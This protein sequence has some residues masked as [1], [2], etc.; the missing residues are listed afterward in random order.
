MIS[1]SRRWLLKV[2]AAVGG[3]STLTGWFPSLKFSSA[4]MLKQDDDR[5]A[6]DSVKTKTHIAVIGAGAFG[7]WT[8]LYLLRNGA[9]VTLLDAWGP[10]NSRA[11][12]GGE[13]R[14]IRGTYGPNQPYTKMAARA[15]QL[16]KEH[17]KRWN[18]K[19]LHQTG[20]LWMVAA[21]DDHF[22]RE[23][24]PALR[25]AGIPYQELSVQEMTSR[26]PQINLDGVHWGIYEPAGGFLT[27]RVACQAVVD[28]FLAEGG[29][30]R[31]A[32]VVSHDLDRKWDNLSLS[33]GSKLE[34]DQYVFAC[35]PWLGKLFPETVGNHIRP[36]KQDVFFFGAPAGDDRFAE[37]K[38]PVWADHRDRFI[39]GIPGNQGRGFKVADDTRGPAFDPTS[40]ERTISAEGLKTIRDYVAFRFPALKDAPLLESRVCQYENSPDNNFIIDRH[41]GYDNLW[42]L[43]GGS[44]HG[45]K[46][47]P[48]LGEMVAGLV[49]ERKDPDALFRLARFRK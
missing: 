38:L 22:E 3:A 1:F 46:H 17:E 28:G 29:E 2:A 44:G 41:P 25:D 40:G 39:Y 30:Y 6:T 18:L 21:G 27:A 4:N 33:D 14:V 42:L 26:W 16:W 5:G 15:T 10:G 8:A 43:G 7:G 32:A 23:S 31:Q 19:L 37:D 49:A 12:S 9:R 35:G 45:F 24:L 20:V 47:G 13:T 11:S 48:A 36:T 34:A